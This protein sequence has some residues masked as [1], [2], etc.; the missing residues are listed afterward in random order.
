MK[1]AI[2]YHSKYG[3]TQQIAEFLGQEIQAGGHE[4][5]L[6]RTK[7]TEPV[8]VIAFQ[9][10]A[11]LVGG[12]THFGKP[13]GLGKFLKKLG[14]HENQL[15]IRIA[16]VFNCYTGDIVCEMIENQISDTFPQ[17][18]IFEKSLPICTSADGENWKELALPSNWKQVASNFLSTF[19][20]SLS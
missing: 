19:L 3:N 16:A 14:K 6:F 7:K 8:E 18:Q 17:I 10:E 5:Q 11:I 13:A 20:N 9:P 4:V 2:L 12:P 1:I 15:S